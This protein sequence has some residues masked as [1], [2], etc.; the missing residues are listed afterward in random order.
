MVDAG[1]DIFCGRSKHWV[2]EEGE[3]FRKGVALLSETEMEE[4]EAGAG[5]G[6]VDGEKGRVMGS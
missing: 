3:V 6:L 5:R 1:A 4:E 2:E